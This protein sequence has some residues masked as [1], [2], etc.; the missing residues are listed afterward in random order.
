MSQRSN[1]KAK[2]RSNRGWGIKFGFLA[3]VGASILG[4]SLYRS[5]AEATADRVKQKA[6]ETVDAA[7][8]YAKE[9]KQEFQARMEKNL[10]DVESN[11]AELKAEATKT[12]EKSRARFDEEL[13]RL[14][15]KR[16]QMRSQLNQLQ[17]SSGRAWT[18]MRSGMER[19]W[20]DLKAACSDAKRELKSNNE[21]KK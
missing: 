6:S 3:I 16:A 18:K 7:S 15:A 12:T 2:A 10:S 21:P 14:E 8:D 11:I 17:E 4:L 9:T 19:A 13:Q 20:T 1:R 5:R